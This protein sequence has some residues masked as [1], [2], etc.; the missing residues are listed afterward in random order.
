MAWIA[1]LELTLAHIVIL[2]LTL[3]YIVILELNP[4]INYYSVDKPRHKL[5]FR[6]PRLWIAIPVLHTISVE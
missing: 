5:L 3:A 6:R 1:A 2:E 4:C